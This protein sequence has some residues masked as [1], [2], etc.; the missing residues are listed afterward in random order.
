MA[1]CIVIAA[2]ALIA[3]AAALIS[4]YCYRR[5]VRDICRRLAFIKSHKTNMK[6]DIE[7]GSRDLNALC[8]EINETLRKADRLFVETDRAERNLRCAV[9]DISHDIRTPL[10]SLD[11]YFQLLSESADEEERARYEVIIRTRIESLNTMLEELFTYARLH[12]GLEIPLSEIDFGET[13]IK[14][15]LSFYDSFTSAGILPEV[16]FSEEKFAVVSNADALTRVVQNIIKNALVHGSGS[17]EMS[18]KRHGENAVFTCKNEIG[19]SDIDESMV[20]ERFY[21]ADKARSKNS[22]GLGLA[23]A[24]D[25]AERA[26]CEISAHVGG[27]FFAIT[28][29]APLYAEY[30][31][32]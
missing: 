6:L 17:V 5:Q 13:V 10:T 18:L 26:G 4:L 9:A 31:G 29:S 25:L 21:K 20:F 27:G 14:T 24:H 12:G 19:D 15:A 23:I 16:D 30:K 7:T 11:G 22:T 1:W 3:A 8:D 2:A 32:E 28:L